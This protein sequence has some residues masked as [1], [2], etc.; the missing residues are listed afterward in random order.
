MG[1]NGH[2]GSSI[3]NL[4]LPPPEAAQSPGVFPDSYSDLV[5]AQFGPPADSTL[6]TLDD[7]AYHA[8]ISVKTLRRML[9][10]GR[11]GPRPIIVGGRAQR[12]LREEVTEW[13]HAGCPRRADW[14]LERGLRKN[15]PTKGQAKN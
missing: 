11:F 3:P 6:W 4:P 9:A 14:E 7:I 12:F 10:S 15:G 13:L 2:D 8:R 5:I 1:V